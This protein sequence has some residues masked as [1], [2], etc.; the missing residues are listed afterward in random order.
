MAGQWLAL[1]YATPQDNYMTP[2]V[3]GT[4]VNPIH[5]KR[6]GEGRNTAP[7]GN[8]AGE[9]NPVIVNDDDF[10]PD[11]DYG[12]GMEDSNDTIWGY[13]VDTGTADRA[14]WGS[15]SENDRNDTDMGPQDWPSAGPTPTG[16]PAGT[17]IRSI[18][19][20][21]QA[22]NTMK[23]IQPPLIDVSTA[24]PNDGA[25]PFD[26]ETSDDAQIFIQTS[27]VQRDKVRE[28]S[29][30]S[31]TASE[32]DAP[33][34]SRII[35]PKMKAIDNSKARHSDMLPKAQDLIVRPFWVRT[36]GTGPRDWLQPNEFNPVTPRQRVSP[37]NPDQGD[38]ITGS[39]NFVSAYAGTQ[40]GY[41]DEELTW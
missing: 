14:S 7:D 19:R 2:L 1:N 9:V 34:K 17:A 5:S 22:T 4:G 15:D 3:W 28:G 38:E 13:G 26:S 32:Q 6:I 33:I 23:G 18:D 41:T 40:Y 31:G 8:P 27:R 21:S 39:G 36:A 20:G 24:P 37:D 29:Q 16:V 12:Y 10:V 25:E 11:A 35:G 30:I